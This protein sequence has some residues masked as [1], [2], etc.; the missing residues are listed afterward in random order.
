MSSYTGSESIPSIPSG[1]GISTGSLR[2]AEGTESLPS[3]GG[4]AP[5]TTYYYRSPLGVRGNTT[6]VGSIPVGSVIERI[7]TT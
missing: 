5:V 3:G 4:T 6:S 1:T 7:V 2:Y